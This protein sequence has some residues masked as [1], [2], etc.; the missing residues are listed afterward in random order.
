MRARGRRRDVR[1]RGPRLR[2]PRH[3][4]RGLY[5]GPGSDTLLGGEGGDD[6]HGGRG[7]DDLRGGPGN[8]TLVGE[9]GYE[10]VDGDPAGSD[11]LAGGSGNDYFVAEDG[12]KDLVYCGRGRQDYVE[13][14]GSRG[15]V[16]GDYIDDSCE[17]VN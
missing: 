12:E 7:S 15:G 2:P 5:G 1:P 14:D 13:A 3:I 10:F 6:L 8:D 4:R 17:N 9:E 16:R 11:R